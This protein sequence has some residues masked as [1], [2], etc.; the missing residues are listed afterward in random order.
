MLLQMAL[1]HSC[2]WLSN[3][4]LYI[5]ITSSLSIHQSMDIQVASM[6]WLL[7]RALQWTL[8]CRHPFELWFSPP[9]SYSSVLP[10][11]CPNLLPHPLP[12]SLFFVNLNSMVDKLWTLVS[13]QIPVVCGMLFCPQCNSSC[14]S[15]HRGSRLWEL[16]GGWH[17]LQCAIR[18][19]H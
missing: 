18:Y 8:G 9:Y 6:S 4:P 17:R 13:S 12:V 7:W 3:I 19:F 14:Y 11:P 10:L 16:W 2:L 1:F 5:C 15:Q